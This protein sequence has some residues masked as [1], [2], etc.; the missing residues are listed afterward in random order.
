MVVMNQKTMQALVESKV[1]LGTNATLAAGKGIKGKLLSTD[2]LA[3]IYYFALVKGGIFAGLNL[4]GGVNEPRDK[5]NQ[6][7]YGK[8]ASARAVVMERTVSSKGAA[9]LIKALSP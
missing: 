8:E 2:Q 1:E 9:K 7:Y 5:L 4:K 3:D 6:T